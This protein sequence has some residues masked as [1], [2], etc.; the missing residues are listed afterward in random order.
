MNIEHKDIDKFIPYGEAL[1]GFVN[2]RFITPAVIHKILQERGIFA[3]TNDKDYTAPLLQTLLLSPCEFD[4]IR[5]AFSQKEDNEKIISR[6]INWLPDTQ[7]D[8]VINDNHIDQS[9]IQQIIDKKIP[10]CTLKHIDVASVDSDDNHKIIKFELERHDL[11]KSWYEQ[12]N[13]FSGSLEFINKPG[14]GAVKITHTSSETKDFAESLLKTEIQ[15]FKTNK[16]IPEE[17]TPRK[18]SFSDFT[19]K[20]RF[21]FLFKLSINMEDSIFFVCKGIDDIS[22]RPQDDT[23][24]PEEI[25]WMED[26]R[27]IIISGK[28]V[29]DKYFMKEDKFREV[30]VLYQIQT[31]Y[32]YTYNGSSGIVIVNMGFPD[33][34]KK[35]SE[36]EFEIDIH[37]VIP[38]KGLPVTQSK[39]LKSKLLSEFDKQKSIIYESFKKQR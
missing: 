3:M 9:Q 27:K 30:I 37:K 4:K 18:I 21:S 11:N 36:S 28:N 38:K 5:E 16:L 7:L 13:T 35:G 26:T 31:R 8:S 22:M 29:G 32:E 24:L 1:R 15:S 14:E 39:S 10:T 25:K 2:Q 20:E 19:N 6:E 33:F 12:S 23:P 34:P 17:E